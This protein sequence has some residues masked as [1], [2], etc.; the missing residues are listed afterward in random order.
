MSHDRGCF[1]C[2][3]DKPDGKVCQLSACPYRIKTVDLSKPPEGNPVDWFISIMEASGYAF[4]PDDRR[5]LESLRA[6]TEEPVASNPYQSGVLFAMQ[7]IRRVATDMLKE[8]YNTPSVASGV[9]DSI[10][11]EVTTR[12][13]SSLHAHMRT[14]K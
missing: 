6:W 1:E 9:R 7:D 10:I 13:W 14:L 12:I 11:R 4:A 3:D 2:G 8:A 5:N